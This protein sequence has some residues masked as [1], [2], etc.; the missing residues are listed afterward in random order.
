MGKEI[1]RGS[2]VA[3]VT[4]FRGGGVDYKALDGLVDWHLASGTHGI[5]PLGTTGESPTVDDAERT[6][7][8]KTV[9]G[10]AKGKTAVIAGTGTNDTRKSVAYTKEAKDLGADGALIVTPYYNKPTQEGIYRHVEAIAKAA[11]LPLC[12]Y[13]IPYRSGVPIEPATAARCAKLPQVVAIKEASGALEYTLQLRQLCDL[14]VLSGEDSLTF[15]LMAVGAKGIISVAANVVPKEMADLCNRAL[16][17][18]WNTARELHAGLFSLMKA[19]FLETN[20]IP[21]K[22][23]LKLMGKIDGE[24]RLPLCPM[25]EANEAKL[26]EVLREYRLLG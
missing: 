2:I 24:L 18:D 14:V 1:Y 23:A 5:I 20:P 10:R 6:K 3:L 26:R 15:P 22:T 12:L 19:M 7:I 21:V 13:N 9:I 17:G 16:A 8:L 25:S 11:D 4:P